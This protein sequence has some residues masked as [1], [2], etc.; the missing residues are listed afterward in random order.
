MSADLINTKRRQQ[1]SGFS[2]VIYILLQCGVTDKSTNIL[3]NF[4][5][6]NA[7][8]FGTFVTLFSL[9]I[10]HLQQF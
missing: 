7:K 3:N 1:H 8:W 5:F 4:K 10:P 9:M 2:K 6:V